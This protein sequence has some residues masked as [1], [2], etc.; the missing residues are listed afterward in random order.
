[1]IDNKLSKETLMQW[2]DEISAP[3][4]AVDTIYDACGS[5]T[6]EDPCEA[7][8]IIGMCFKTNAK[9]FKSEM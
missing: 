2:S 7:G 3:A 8:A 5:L 9:K 1:M 6:H 4:D